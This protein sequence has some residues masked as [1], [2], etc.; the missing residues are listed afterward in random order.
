MLYEL[1]TDER[2]EFWDGEKITL[3]PGAPEHEYVFSNLITVVNNY[4][5]QHK[6]GKMFGSNTALYLHGD[7]N[8]SDFRLPDFTFVAEHRLDIVQRKGIY[9]A[10]DLIVEVLSPGKAN[11]DRDRIVKYELYERFGVK[12][13]WI[14]HPY[15]ETIEMYGLQ[16][17][18]YVRLEQS[19]LF[20]GIVLNREDIFE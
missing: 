11:T 7:V 1:E 19:A 14:V 15:D 5:K 4:V 2:Y 13:Y 20:P 10:P 6:L 9:G 18:R 8:R 12:E 17:G 16:G 3:T